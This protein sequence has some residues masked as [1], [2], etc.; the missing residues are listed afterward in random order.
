MNRLQKVDDSQRDSVADLDRKNAELTV[1][2]QSYVY[3]IKNMEDGVI[4]ANKQVEKYEQKM[5]EMEKEIH[6]LRT[7]LAKANAGT[8]AT[9]AQAQYEHR[10]SGIHKKD[11]Y[12]GKTVQIEHKPGQQPTLSFFKI[13]Q[14]R[15]V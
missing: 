4:T 11:P 13:G 5:T 14:T 7:L 15:L 6:L 2:T 10:F 12:E 9:V 1:L 8:R 3:Q